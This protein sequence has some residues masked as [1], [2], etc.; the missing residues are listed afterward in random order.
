MT[1]IKFPAF[2]RIAVVKGAVTPGNVLCS[3]S[4]KGVKMV[5]QGI[6]SEFSGSMLHYATLLP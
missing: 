2:S 6:V 5:C 1:K 4:Q 3:L